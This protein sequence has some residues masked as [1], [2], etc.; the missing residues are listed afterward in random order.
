MSYSIAEKLLDCIG[1][2]DDFYLA[3]AETADIA[4]TKAAKRKRLVKY[5][6]AGLAVSVGL[7]VAYWKFRPVKT[8]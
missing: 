6:F 5:S 2:I 1:G 3:E 4:I 8:A 7:A